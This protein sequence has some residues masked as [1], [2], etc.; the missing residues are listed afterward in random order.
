MPCVFKPQQ[1]LADR[2]AVGGVL[3]K[4]AP[5]AREKG[6]ATAMP[7]PVQA[8]VGLALGRA[9]SGGFPGIGAVRR[10]QLGRA[11]GGFAQ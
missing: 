6:G 7:Q 11:D 2:S 4:S 1:T 5:K 10:E 3:L 9:R 8:R